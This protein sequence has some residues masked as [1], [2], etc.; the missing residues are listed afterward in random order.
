MLDKNTKRA[1]T[2]VR[3]L[4]DAAADF[5]IGRDRCLESTGI[6]EAELYATDTLITLGQETRVI[7]NFIAA[8]P[9]VSGLG[10]EIGKRYHLNAFGIWG[11]AIL[12]SPT[13]RAAIMTATEYAKLSFLIAEMS[14]TDDKRNAKIIFDTS[15]LPDN[16]TVS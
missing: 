16:V 5:G 9:G 13:L 10:V 14:L 3:I 1:A 7:E 4:C 6:T 8:L 15:A 11:F 2:S 12:T